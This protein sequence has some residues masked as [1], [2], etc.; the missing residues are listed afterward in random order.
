[1]LGMTNIQATSFI[2]KRLVNINTI[3]TCG[4][5]YDSEGKESACNEG[6]LGLIPGLGRFP[7]GEHGNPL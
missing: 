4:L 3:Y 1:M 2:K 6:D 7:E 5:P